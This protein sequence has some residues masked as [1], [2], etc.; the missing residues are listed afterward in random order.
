MADRLGGLLG[1]VRHGHSVHPRVDLVA[2]LVGA[3]HLQRPLGVV[4]GV[5]PAGVRV[6]PGPLEVGALGERAAA[7]GLEQRVDRVDGA[8]AC[9]APGRGGPS[10]AGSSGIF[11]PLAT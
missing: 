7:G 5:H 3:V 10:A 4:G 11:S 2:E 9:R 6:A 8:L 1:E